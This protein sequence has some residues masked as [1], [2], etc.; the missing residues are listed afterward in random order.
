MVRRLRR[1]KPAQQ[2]FDPLAQPLEQSLH[3]ADRRRRLGPLGGDGNRAGAIRER[4]R[5]TPGR[6][7]GI[8]EIEEALARSSPRRARRIR[9][10]LFR[11]E[12]RPKHCRGASVA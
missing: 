11:L 8:G 12:G 1:A 7:A 4:L 5:Q 6:P 10:L 9:E 3:Q 2:P